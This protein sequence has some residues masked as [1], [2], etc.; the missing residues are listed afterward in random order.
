MNA[1]QTVFPPLYSFH[2]R[3][4]D[5]YFWP[6]TSLCSLQSSLQGSMS[7][8]DTSFSVRDFSDHVVLQDGKWV[9]RRY[10]PFHAA[11]T[12]CLGNAAK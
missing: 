10:C 9:A 1:V 3:D 11:R 12:I 2:G 7:G 4:R 6:S 8:A 5:F